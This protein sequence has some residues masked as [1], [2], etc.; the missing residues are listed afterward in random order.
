MIETTLIIGRYYFEIET[1]IDIGYNVLTHV[2][3]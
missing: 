2:H 1:R 3:L